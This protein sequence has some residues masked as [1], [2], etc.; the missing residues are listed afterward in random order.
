MLLKEFYKERRV[1]PSLKL[2]IEEQAEGHFWIHNGGDDYT[3]S[4]EIELSE[5]EKKKLSERL[6]KYQK[7]M[8]EFAEFL[9]KKYFES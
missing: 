2:E 9:M 6:V 1:E 5:D 4:R 8:K 7:E 3:A